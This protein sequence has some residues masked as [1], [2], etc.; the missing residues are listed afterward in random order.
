MPRLRRRGGTSTPRADHETRNRDRQGRDHIDALAG[1]RL[2]PGY[3][4]ADRKREHASEHGGDQPDFHGVDD[5]TQHQRVRE[6]PIV[7][8]GAIGSEIEQRRDVADEHELTERGDDKRKR[9]QDHH[10]E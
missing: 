4:V 9:R 8:N 10:D 6:Q 7:M 3:R 5:R 2:R 1:R